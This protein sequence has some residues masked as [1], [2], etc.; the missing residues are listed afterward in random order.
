MARKTSVSKCWVPVV[1]AA[2]TS[3]LVGAPP[4][5]AGPAAATVG[6]TPSAALIVGGTSFP[7]LE[8]S[9]MEQLWPTWSTSLGLA[10]ATVPDL[11]NVA[12]PAQLYPFTDGEFLGPSVAAGVNN[13]L[14]LVN[15]TYTAGAHLIV[16]GISQGALVLD[17]AQRMLAGNPAAPPPGSLTFV[18]VADPAASITGMLNFLPDLIMSKFLHLE[19]AVRTPVDSQYNTI[20]VTNEYDAFADFPNRPWNLLAVANAIVGLWY[21]HAQTGA[22]DL[23]AVPAQNISTTVN[24]QGASTT[25]YLVPSPLLPLTQPLRDAGVAAGVVDKLDAALRPIVDAG[26]TRNEAAVTPAD[27]APAAPTAVAAAHPSPEEI[28]DRIAR[29]T[30]PP[31]RQAIRAAVDA[32]APPAAAAAGTRSSDGHGSRSQR[33]DR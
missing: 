28:T 19:D 26:Y 16:W 30:T 24:S 4:A 32:K 33:R 10:N 2:A 25:T 1:V 22:A 12:Y 6:A 20:V 13:L 3:G 31:R 8:Q 18:R 29:P 15:T 14:G 17:S 27:T 7:T 21:R 9:F 23:T 11:I 5:A